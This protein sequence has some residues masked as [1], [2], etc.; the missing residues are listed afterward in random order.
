MMSVIKVGQ[1]RQDVTSSLLSLANACEGR[2]EWRPT[3]HSVSARPRPT[4]LQNLRFGKPTPPS[5]RLNR[6]TLKMW[7]MDLWWRWQNLNSRQRL[8]YGESETLE[9]KS[10]KG[11]TKSANRLHTLSGASDRSGGSDELLLLF[12]VRQGTRNCAVVARQTRKATLF[13]LSPQLFGKA[14]FFA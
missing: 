10:S 11:N 2:V 5:G 1:R 4:T 13:A 12:L 7:I 14:S 9:Y 8:S 6:R 3:T